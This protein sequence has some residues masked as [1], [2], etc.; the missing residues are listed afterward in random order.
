[1]DVFWNYIDQEVKD[2]IMFQVGL[3]QE[4]VV[5]DLVKLFKFIQEIVESIFKIF[6]LIKCLLYV[7]ECVNLMGVDEQFLVNEANK[8]VEVRLCKKEQECQWEVCQQEC[9]CCLQE[10]FLLL[11]FKLLFQG[12]FFFGV[13]DELFFFIE[14]LG[15][16]IDLLFEELLF[17][18]ILVFVWEKLVGDGF[19]EWD[20]VWILVIGGDV[21][22][23][24]EDGFIVVE[25]FIVNVEDVFD[26]FDNSLYQWVF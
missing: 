17:E 9:V 25:Y 18:E 2:F 11:F 14:E 10:V 19:Q 24:Q 16:I 12:L 7:W 20:L 6:D 8:V 26:E 23:D 13:G 15:G 22:F 21:Q 3:L 5:G 1:M 4:E